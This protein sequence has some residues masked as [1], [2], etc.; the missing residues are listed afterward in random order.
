MTWTG[1]W[2]ARTP[3]IGL[4]RIPV[5]NCIDGR[6]KTGGG[7]GTRPKLKRRMPSGHRGLS[8]GPK[9]GKEGTGP[10]A[11]SA[12]TRGWKSRREGGIADWWYLDDGDIMCWSNMVLDYL[13]VFDEMNPK[14]GAERNTKI[15][16]S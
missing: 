8:N 6:V 9:M 4:Q 1:P 11:K 7:W 16:K 3:L 5:K 10:A 13:K 2:N 15:Q 12:R 14:V